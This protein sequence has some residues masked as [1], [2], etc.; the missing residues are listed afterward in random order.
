M[1]KVAFIFSG[2]CLGF[3]GSFL[4]LLGLFVGC[5]DVFLA[6]LDLL[7]R[8]SYHHLHVSPLSMR[9]RAGPAPLVPGSIF[10]AH[11]RARDVF[12]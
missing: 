2:L 7:G 11:S 12:P 4:G 1:E 9:K 10:V 5:L 3:G 8:L 6:H